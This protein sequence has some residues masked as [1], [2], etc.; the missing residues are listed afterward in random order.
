MIL[1][2]APPR[3]GGEISRRRSVQEEVCGGEFV[4]VKK[5]FDGGHLG[6]EAVCSRSLSQLQFVHGG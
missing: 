5:S 4:W 1:A 6:F 3:V 2:K